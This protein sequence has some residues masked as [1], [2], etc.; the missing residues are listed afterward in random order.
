MQPQHYMCCMETLK[1]DNRYR[2]WR[3]HSPSRL[4]WSEGWRCSHLAL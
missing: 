4:A 1:S 3:T 2:Y